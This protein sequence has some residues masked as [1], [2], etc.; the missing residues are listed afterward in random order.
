VD[1]RVRRCLGMVEVE[2]WKSFW[3]VLWGR[4]GELHENTGFS[5]SRRSLRKGE[6]YL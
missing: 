6:G 4:I 1:R 5:A 3:G 2:V